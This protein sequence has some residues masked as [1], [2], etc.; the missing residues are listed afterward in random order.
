MPIG[1]SSYVT[2]DSSNLSR[3][4][5]NSWTL[6]MMSKNVSCKTLWHMTFYWST[7]L[8]VLVLNRWNNL[9]GLSM[10]R[11]SVRTNRKKCYKSWHNKCLSSL[12]PLKELRE[13]VSQRLSWTTRM[14]CALWL[15]ISTWLTYLGALMWTCLTIIYLTFRLPRFSV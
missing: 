10:L 2:T 9:R 7:S 6:W 15:T 4:S 5:L 14:K 8:R 13:T 11:E 12:R 1:S 3:M